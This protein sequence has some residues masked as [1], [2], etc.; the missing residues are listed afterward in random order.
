MGEAL[1]LNSAMQAL[2]ALRQ[3]PEQPQE[4]AKEVSQEPVQEV[5]SEAPEIEAEVTEFGETLE[6]P[7]P[8]GEELPESGATTEAETFDLGADE[9]ASL[10]GIKEDLINVTDDGKVQFRA[11]VGDEFSDVPL[12]KLVNAYQ[13]DANLTNRSKALSEKEKQVQSELAR[14]HQQST[15]FAQQAAAILET[16]KNE[17]LSPYSKEELNALRQDDPAEYAAR[18]EEIRDR[19]RRFN[20]IVN[21]A[22]KTAR[23]AQQTVS[24]DT[25]RY[26]ANYLQQEAQKVRDEVK[27]WE[28]VEKDVVSY[29]KKT[30]WQDQEIGMI[31]DSRIQ[32]MMYKAMMFDKGKESVK[33]KLSKP[34]P[35]ITK[36]GKSPTKS[37]V[38]L[39]AQSK[40]RLQL[41]KSGNLNDAVAVLKNRRK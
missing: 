1:D 26:Y 14:Y 36:P 16:V 20:E 22:V 31:A 8:K 21:G 41:K 7:E 5:E 29:A 35:R 38:S 10:L 4:Q 30:G 28:K 27:D 33:Q 23:E 9:L 39:E 34:I 17:F 13:G 11:K 32:I 6:T 3:P 2:K 25:Q 12:E 18:K 19:E 40:A 24:E 15:E 37:Q